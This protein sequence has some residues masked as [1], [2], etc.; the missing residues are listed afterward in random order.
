MN[1]ETES[2]MP[3]QAPAVDI[4]KLR[5]TPV[6]IHTNGY[7][8]RNLRH[9][10]ITERFMGW[11]NTSEMSSGLNIGPTNFDLPKLT[12][13]IQSFEN[14][15]RYFI[16]IFDSRTN[17]LIGFYTIDVTPQHRVG[18]LTAAIGEEDYKRKDVFH[19]TIDAL[20]DHFFAE[21]DIEKMTARVIARNWKMLFN[22]RDSLR[23]MVDA[24]LAQ[25]CL[26]PVG[27]R[28][29]VVSFAAF[30]NPPPGRGIR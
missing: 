28:V 29:D 25:E 1:A 21:R 11:L 27:D 2:A 17:L 14:Y 18:T 23:F 12:Q 6:V 8:L 4:D 15:R 24:H 13:F 22:L 26:T 30:K 20:L 5:R 3:Y 7:T 16:G 9:A 10:D 19:V